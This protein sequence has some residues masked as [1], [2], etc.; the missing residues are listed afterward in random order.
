[1]SQSLANVIV[2]FV[3]STKGR[4]PW[5]TEHA[6]CV[7]LYKYM[8]TSLK[9]FDSPSIIINGVS[10]HVHILCRLS[11]NHAIKTVVGNIKADSSKW[12]KTKGEVYRDFHWQ[13]GYG[14]FSVS[15]SRADDVQRYIAQQETHHKRMTFQ[16]E[17]RTLCRRNEVELDERY[18][19]D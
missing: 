7:E 14:A 12:I 19:W 16:D 2:H 1:M 6:H 4:H 13:A 18:A 11:R 17:F 15:Q 5:L 9:T 10:D 8:A 3:F